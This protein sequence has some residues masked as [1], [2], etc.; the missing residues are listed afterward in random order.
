MTEDILPFELIIETY[1]LPWV[2]KNCK[3][4]DKYGREVKF[5]PQSIINLITD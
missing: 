2:R 4:Y 3:V 5:V 1:P